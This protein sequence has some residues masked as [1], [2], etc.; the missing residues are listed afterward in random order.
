MLRKHAG[1]FTD[2]EVVELSELYYAAKAGGSVPFSDFIEA[3]DRVAEKGE[4]AK[5]IDNNPIGIRRELVEYYNIGKPHQYTEDQLNI[6]LTHRAPEGYLDKAAYYSC[7]AVRK[8][9][10]KATAWRM[11]N[12]KVDNTLNRVIYLETIAAVPGMVAAVVR[13]F[14]SL[15]RMSSDGGRIALFLEEATNER[16]VRRRIVNGETTGDDIP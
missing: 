3:I 15:R 12:I 4:G 9:F 8:I 11:D 5:S 6:D 7:Q 13:H 2:A 10:D 16:Y 1:A 14:S